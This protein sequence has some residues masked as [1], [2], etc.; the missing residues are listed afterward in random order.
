MPDLQNATI[1]QHA[2]H[3]GTR[4]LA[5]ILDLD[6][7]AAAELLAN[8]GQISGQQQAALDQTE[9]ILLQAKKGRINNQAIQWHDTITLRSLRFTN[10]RPVFTGLR[11]IAG[12]RLEIQNIDDPVKRALS[13]MCL[14]SYP[15]TLFQE[16][17]DQWGFGSID[18]PL[19]HGTDSLAKFLSAVRSDKVLMKLFPDGA[20]DDLASSR[21]YYTSFGSGGGVQ[22][23]LLHQNILQ[24]G[25]ALM[26]AKNESSVHSLQ[27]AVW[28]MLDVLR[29]SLSKEKTVLPVFDTFDLVGLPDV[30]QTSF[31]ESKL[32]GIPKSFL[33]HIPGDARPSQNGEG[34]VFGGMLQ[35]NCKFDIF[36]V[37]P[38]FERDIGGGWPIEISSNKNLEHRN[39]VSLATSLAIENE[40]TTAA[41]WRSTITIDPLRGVGQSWSSKSA[42]LG[43]NHMANQDECVRLAD[44]LAIISST[45]I[46]QIDMTISRF[47]SATINRD[48]LQDSLVDAVIGMESLFGGRAEISFSV[49]SGVANLLGQN[50]ASRK[51]LFSETKQ[52]YDARS[53]LVHGSQKKVAKLDIPQIRNSAVGILKRCLLELLENRSELLPLSSQERVKELVIG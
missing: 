7:G 31:G 6:D 40:N 10:G 43:V 41:R 20:D 17:R 15:F 52:I 5:F 9:Q 44:Q 18:L 19:F 27:V 46:G 37:P 45:D 33:R 3:L 12:G 53:A 29:S 50:L 25:I 39:A 21:Q 49:A 14:E 4:L 38:N 35:R 36:V 42:S 22:I 24:S 51:D 16:T 26:H 34:E 23:C 8:G 32:L 28:E 13:E 2:R 48:D 1:P 11:E 30:F 47:V